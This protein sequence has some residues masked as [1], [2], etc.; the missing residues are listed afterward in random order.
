MLRLER[1]VIALRPSDPHHPENL[2]MTLAPLL[3][4]GNATRFV[5]GLYEGDLVA[6]GLLVLVLIFTAVGWFFKFRS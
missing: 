5:Q 4:R 1:G 6:W 2:P 3:A